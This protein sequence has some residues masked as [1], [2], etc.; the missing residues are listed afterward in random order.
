T[1]LLWD[2]RGHNGV[3]FKTPVGTESFAPFDGRVMRRNWSTRYNGNCLHIRG[4]NG[5]IVYF[6]HLESF[7]EGMEP[8]RRVRKGELI[9]LSGN[10]G[11]SYAPHLHY[12]L[13]NSAGRV[14]DPFEVQE[15]YRE[16]V[17]VDQKPAFDAHVARLGSILEPVEA[18]AADR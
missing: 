7:A 6:L 16:S 11:R 4:D 13:R 3:D 5:L 8:G 14:L 10:T 15:S 2:G 12:E 18:Y 9:G 17:P 1:S